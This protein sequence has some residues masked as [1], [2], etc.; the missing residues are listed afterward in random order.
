M[1]RYDEKCKFDAREDEIA[2]AYE[3]R[4]GLSY[5]EHKSNTMLKNFIKHQIK[6][7]EDY[8]KICKAID[9]TE[10]IVKL[11]HKICDLGTELQYQVHKNKELGD[12]DIY[13]RGKL[14]AYE[15]IVD[16]IDALMEEIE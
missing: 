9:T 4:T 16:K 1:S 7:V 13:Y 2:A 10:K 8:K 14:A 5:A 11:E 15:E 6:S 12:T 3:E